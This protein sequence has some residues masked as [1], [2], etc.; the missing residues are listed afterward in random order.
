MGTVIESHF[1]AFTA[2]VTVIIPNSQLSS[3]FLPRLLLPLLSL[4]HLLP[5]LKPTTT[6][7]RAL[8]SPSSYP[9][10]TTTKNPPPTPTFLHQLISFSNAAS[11]LPHPKGTSFS[12][13]RTS[14][15][16]KETVFGLSSIL[17]LQRKLRALVQMVS[18]E[19]SAWEKRVIT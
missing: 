10:K 12:R 1:L 13:R 15:P 3:L 4:L 19:A 17:L 6:T 11:P 8:A 5:L 18:T 7:T 14:V 16:E 2:L 9:R